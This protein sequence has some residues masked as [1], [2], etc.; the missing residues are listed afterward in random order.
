MPPIIVMKNLPKIPFLK[1]F[2]LLNTYL[3][4]HLFKLILLILLITAS[5]I[6][7]VINPLIL[8]FFIDEV[9]QIENQNISVLKQAILIYISVAVV[10]QILTILSVYFGLNLAWDTTNQ[11]RYDLLTHTLD[12]DMKFHNLKKPGE[13]IERIDGDVLQLSTFFSTL[14]LYLGKNIFLIISILISLFLVNGI[15]GIVFTIFTFIG[16]YFMIISSKPAVKHW[17]GVRENAAKM[18]GFIEERISGKEDI[19]ALGAEQA[20]M[21]SFHA[22]LKTQ[23]D[24]VMKATLASNFVRIIV[25]TIVGVSTI[26]VYAFGIPLTLREGG[27]TLGELYLIADYIRL[28]TNPIINIGFRTQELQRADAAIDRVG[29]LLMT[30]KEL[31]DTGQQEIETQDFS[32]E[33]KDLS[34]EYITNEPVLQNINLRIQSGKSI[35]LIGRTGSGKTTLSRLIFRLYDP[36]SGSIKLGDHDLREF[37]LARLREKVAMVTQTVELFNGTVRENITLFNP[38]ISDHEIMNAIKKVGLLKWYNHLEFGLDT[39]ITGGESISAGEAQLLAFTRVFLKDP[40]LVILDEASSRLDPVSEF[41]IDKA[42]NL[43]LKG[44]T[45]IIIAHKLETLNRVDDIVILKEGSILESGNREKLSQDPQSMYYRLIHSSL[46]EIL[47]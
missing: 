32:V 31:E 41:L 46:E 22:T 24:V 40:D 9:L 37:S 11:L 36:I 28:I 1:Y 15:I 35:G 10:A 44:R 6:L 27:L 16:L 43:L 38:H 30:K 13:M 4:P 23:H 18:Y 19:R 34:F 47:A 39:R 45:S 42:I 17:S 33:F 26:L 12:L 20:T 25:Y 29:E 7:S 3:Q 21:K 8:R 2:K 14:M 5:T